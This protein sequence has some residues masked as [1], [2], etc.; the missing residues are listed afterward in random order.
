MKAQN[1]FLIKEIV[2]SIRMLIRAVCLDSSKMSKEFG[3]TGPQ[4]SVLRI[5]ARRGP[6]SSAE[7][8]RHMHVTPSN[9]TGIVD[10]LER[11]GLVERIR[12]QKDRRVVSVRL[13]EDGKSISHSL[14][15]PIENRLIS[16]LS[17]LDSQRIKTLNQALKQILTL[18]DAGKILDLSSA[19]ADEGSLSEM[20]KFCEG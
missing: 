15:D 9:V 1:E 8:S 2:G 12:Q 13:T 18:I 14:P 16:G 11:K 3:L 7:V 5:L 20:G 4:S 19:D 10:R 6:L 17:D